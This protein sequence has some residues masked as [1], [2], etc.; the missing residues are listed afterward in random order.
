MM[1]RVM[2]ATALALGLG[3]GA[4]AT[5]P[6]GEVERVA[7]RAEILAENPKLVPARLSA[8]APARAVETH[9]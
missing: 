9:I 3:A 5:W 2:L 6:E 8:C 1:M 4:L 7:S